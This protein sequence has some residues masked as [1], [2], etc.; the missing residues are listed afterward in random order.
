MVPRDSV[1]DSEML[2]RWIYYGYG[3]KVIGQY[4][5]QN[6]QKKHRYPDIVLKKDNHVIVLELL[7]TG[8]RSFVDSHLNT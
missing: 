4:Y 7:A 6:S 5:L 8:E 2:T 3:W 1:Y